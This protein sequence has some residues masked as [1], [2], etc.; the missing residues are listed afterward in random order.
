MAM[1]KLPCIEHAETHTLVSNCEKNHIHQAE[2]ENLRWKMNVQ[3]YLDF[4]SAA[5]G[6]LCFGHR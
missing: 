5:R 2:F 4:A 1:S 3:K 6:K